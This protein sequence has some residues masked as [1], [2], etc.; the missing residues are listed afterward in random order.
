MRAACRVE[1]LK[2]RRARVPAVAGLVVL[3]APPLLA[4]VFLAAGHVNAANPLSV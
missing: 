4:W 1:L 2:L 3:L